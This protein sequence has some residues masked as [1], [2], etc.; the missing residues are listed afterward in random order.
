[1][2][3]MSYGIPA[4]APRHTSMADY[5]DES[6]AFI[7]KASTQ[8]TCWPQ[9]DAR[10]A[11]RTKCYRIDCES[12]LNALLESYHVAKDNPERYASMSRAANARLKQHCSRAVVQEKLRDFISVDRRIFRSFAADTK[13]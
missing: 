6:V 2:E 12:M 3:F 1:M 11:Y 5:V 13:A 8:P 9:D 4:V 10:T 7:V